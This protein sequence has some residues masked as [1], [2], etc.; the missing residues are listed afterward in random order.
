MSKNKNL[1]TIY[2]GT[3]ENGCFPVY[4]STKR[5]KAERYLHKVVMKDD[6]YNKCY[7]TVKR[8]QKLSR[9]D[10]DWED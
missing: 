7:I 2:A 8:T 4:Q 1:Y 5:E 9:R 3:T 6:R 10:I